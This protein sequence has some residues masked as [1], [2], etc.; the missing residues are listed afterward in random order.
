MGT[1]QFDSLALF[2]IRPAQVF[3]VWCAFFPS[4]P[5]QHNCPFTDCSVWFPPPATPVAAPLKGNTA[6]FPAPPPCLSGW[7]PELEEEGSTYCNQWVGSRAE[8][9]G[10]GSV[11]RL[12]IGWTCRGECAMNVQ[13]LFRYSAEM[14]FMHMS[15]YDISRSTPKPC[16]CSSRDVWS[17]ITGLVAMQTFITRNRPRLYQRFQTDVKLDGWWL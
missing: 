7:L 6:G 2:G 16:I 11:H 10:T 4:L 14:Q 17:C 5:H 8:E 3:P 15:I 1:N 9:T 13:H 12:V